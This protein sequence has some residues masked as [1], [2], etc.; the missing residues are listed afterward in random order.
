MPTKVV[1]DQSQ[2][3]HA[4]KIHRRTFLKE[5][6]L[7]TGTAVL[8]P[9]L[10][11]CSAE[12]SEETTVFTEATILAD[13]VV[14]GAQTA[15]DAATQGYQVGKFDYLDVLDAQRTL[16][17]A[18]GQYIRSLAKYHKAKIDVERLIAKSLDSI[19]DTQEQTK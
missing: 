16:F 17:E 3:L 8:L 12:S 2:G 1:L 13:D 10:A 5:S 15:F 4:N 6:A 11:A 7:L 19:K 9:G 14:P 18:K